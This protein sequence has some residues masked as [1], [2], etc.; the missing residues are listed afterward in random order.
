MKPIKYPVHVFE[1]PEEQVF[2]AGAPPFVIR[3]VDSR[4]LVAVFDR[5][6]ANEVA[7][8]LN[9]HADALPTMD[10]FVPNTRGLIF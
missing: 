3:G 8:I 9:K 4:V 1:V 2:Y 5:E 6:L 7:R 10:K